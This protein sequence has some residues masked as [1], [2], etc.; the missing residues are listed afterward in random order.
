MNRRTFVASSLAGAAAMAGAPPVRTARAVHAPLPLE[1]QDAFALEEATVTQLQEW[2]R[3]GRSTARQ[4]AE[5]YLAR[6]D[7]LDRRGPNLHAVLEPNPDALAIADQLDA[8]RRARGAR[9]PLH[10]VPVLI[11][12]NI[13]TADRMHTSAGSLA[14]AGSLPPPHAVVS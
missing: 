11:K 4:L 12:D 8:E 9:G 5:Q 1:P 13:D 2:M 10:G 7:A 3:V 6:I 14:P